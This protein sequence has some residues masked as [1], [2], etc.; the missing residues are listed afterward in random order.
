MGYYDLHGIILQDVLESK[1]HDGISEAIQH[2]SGHCLVRHL[3]MY[4]PKSRDIQGKTPSPKMVRDA[5]LPGCCERRQL[6]MP[7]GSRL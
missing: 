2:A 3:G 6:Y 5:F 7:V 1:K 4:M